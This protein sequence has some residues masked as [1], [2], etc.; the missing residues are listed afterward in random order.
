MTNTLHNL[1]RHKGA[2]ETNGFTLIE[3]LIVIVVLGILAAV[4]IFALG[5]LTG[6]TA[7]AACQADGATVTTAIADFNAQNA[8]TSVTT[9]GLLNGTTANGKNPYIQSWP[10]NTPHYAFEL[11]TVA[12]TPVLE[13]SITP[14]GTVDAS[15]QA[16][17]KPYKGPASCL[18]AS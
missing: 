4:V 3:V 7:V 6:K 10:S 17:Y 12:G 11:W 2:G 16:N 1:K 13:V 5:G 14:A 9:A 15:A 18:G 8:K